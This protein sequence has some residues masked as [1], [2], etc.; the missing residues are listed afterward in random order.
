MR[1]LPRDVRRVHLG[2]VDRRARAARRAR[3]VPD[4]PLRRQRAARCRRPSARPGHDRGRA[5]R[6]QRVRARRLPELAARDRRLRRRRARERRARRGRRRPDPPLRARVR[7]PRRHG[8]DRRR[9][10]PIRSTASPPGSPAPR[11]ATSDPALTFSL[12]AEQPD[13]RARRRCPPRGRSSSTRRTS[14]TR[15]RPPSR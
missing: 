6:G 14:S 4:R 8:R 7:R 1:A 11:S 9:S 13:G 3:P 15:A 12:P 5:R 2:A 10:R